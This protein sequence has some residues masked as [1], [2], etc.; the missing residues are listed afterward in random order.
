MY[1]SD[2]CLRI[3]TTPY[4]D[5]ITYMNSDGVTV[6]CTDWFFEYWEPTF[7]AEM[8]DFVDCIRQGT[9]PWSTLDDLVITTRLSE[10]IA[11]G[12]KGEVQ[13]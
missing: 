5:R 3:G 6:Q 11:G 10:A 1:G 4:K 12:T 7:L 2:G 8:Q 13:A 9:K